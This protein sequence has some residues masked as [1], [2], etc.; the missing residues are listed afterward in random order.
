MRRNEFVRRILSWR[1][2]LLCWLSPQGLLGRRAFSLPFRFAM[3]LTNDLM[4][5]PLFHDPRF[6]PRAKPRTS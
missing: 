4:H 1:A 6:Y 2:M 3:H 5:S